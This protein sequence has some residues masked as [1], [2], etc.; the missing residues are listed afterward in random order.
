MTLYR[1]LQGCDH[2]SELHWT[3]LMNRTVKQNAFGVEVQEITPESCEADVKK[4]KLGAMWDFKGK[5]HKKQQ[6]LDEV[7][8]RAQMAGPYTR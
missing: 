2:V 7:A 4:W 5:Y 1:C 6:W 3:E 8:Y